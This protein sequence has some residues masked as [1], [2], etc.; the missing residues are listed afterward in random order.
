MLNELGRD[1]HTVVVAQANVEEDQSDFVAVLAHGRKCLAA[2]CGCRDEPEAV[3]C[4]DNI[5]DD[6]AIPVVVIDDKNAGGSGWFVAHRSS[7]WTQR[8]SSVG[9]KEPS[10]HL[11]RWGC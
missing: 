9:G 4:L 2:I 7:L 3:R 5:A 6:V 11:S 8:D 10:Q 1:L